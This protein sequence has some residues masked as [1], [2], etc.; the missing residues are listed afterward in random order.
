MTIKFNL[1][2]T[3]FCD[4]FVAGGDSRIS[5]LESGKLKV[6][7]KSVTFR[8]PHTLAQVRVVIH[9]C[10]NLGYGKGEIKGKMVEDEFS[11][12]IVFS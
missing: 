11:N 4:I 3:M 10:S 2:L 7:G 9:L 8:I 1:K 12:T 5:D 6:F